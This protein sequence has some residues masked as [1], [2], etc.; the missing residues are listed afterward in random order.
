MGTSLLSRYP[1]VLTLEE[2][3]IDEGKLWKLVENDK[4]YGKKVVEAKLQRVKA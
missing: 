2:Q 4:Y 1:E 3:T